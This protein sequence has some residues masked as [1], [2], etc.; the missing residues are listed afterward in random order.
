MTVP[1]A[2]K[3]LWCV[4]LQGFDNPIGDHALKLYAWTKTVI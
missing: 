1:V 4:E 2:G 3:L